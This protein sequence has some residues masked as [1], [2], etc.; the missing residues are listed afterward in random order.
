MAVRINSL[1]NNIFDFFCFILF[2]FSLKLSKNN[3]YFIILIKDVIILNIRINYK[4]NGLSDCLFIKNLLICFNMFCFFS[5]IQVSLIICE[6]LKINISILFYKRLLSKMITFVLLHCFTSH[7]KNKFFIIYLVF[8]VRFSTIIAMFP[9]NKLIF[10][11][12][13]LIFS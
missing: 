3:N 7:I 8:I 6:L 11:C 1:I 4:Y 12:E 2:Y 9:F 10:L 5:I 13:S